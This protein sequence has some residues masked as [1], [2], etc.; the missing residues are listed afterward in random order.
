ME[1]NP[2][3]K[4]HYCVLNLGLKIELLIFFFLSPKREA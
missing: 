4:L 1:A 3:L 2:P